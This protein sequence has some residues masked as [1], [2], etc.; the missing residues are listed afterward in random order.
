MALREVRALRRPLAGPRDAGLGVDDD[1]AVVVEEAGVAQRAQ[2]EQ[3]RRRVAPRAGHEA[4]VRQRLPVVLGE[5][6]DHRLVDVRRRGIPVAALGRVPQPERAGEVEDPDAAGDEVG[7]DLG[8]DRVRQGQEHRP[9]LGRQSVQGE[10]RHVAVPDACER[11]QAAY[12]LGGSR[13]H[14]RGHG[15]G[16]MARGEPEQLLAGVPGGP[17]DPDGKRGRHC[18]YLYIAAGHAVKRGGWDPGAAGMAAGVVWRLGAGWRL[19]G[20]GGCERDS[21]CGGSGL[22]AGTAPTP[23]AT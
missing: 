13:S 15:D 21:G 7:A 10:R 4:C 6:V 20:D 5:A 18:A 8:R 14:G 23:G 2:G 1:V 12:A 11:G 22:E 3:R 19:W 16:R 17:G 9:G